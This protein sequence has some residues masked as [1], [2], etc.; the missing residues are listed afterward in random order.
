MTEQPYAQWF[1]ADHANQPQGP[2]DQDTLIALLR[3]GKINQSS[4]IWKADMDTWQPLDKTLPEALQPF[5]AENPTASAASTIEVKPEPQTIL[6][7]EPATTTEAFEEDSP[8]SAGN[9]STE[10]PVNFPQDEA[11]QT[12]THPATVNV[13]PTQ[14][15]GSTTEK[16]I[17]TSTSAPT[18]PVSPTASHT[19]RPHTADPAAPAKK[20]KGCL[21]A[22]IIGAVLFFIGLIIIAIL[23][24]I[25]IPAY[26]EYTIRSKVA[27]AIAETATYKS[28]VESFYLEHDR[29]PGNGEG[30]IPER[31][32][33]PG[34]NLTDVY[35][36]K[37]LNEDQ[38]ECIIAPT[39]T[40]FGDPELDDQELWMSF[41]ADKNEWLCGA[42]VADKYLPA[43][44]K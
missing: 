29:C 25:A 19:P 24:A 30:G 16:I 5:S 7:P 44:C 38:Y 6:Q 17:P 42:T 12:Q 26:Q 14:T 32:A 20:N 2:V 22:A 1:Y 15:S 37:D 34:N 18:S 13:S 27:G 31:D 21:I 4:L 23:A 33:F 41:D 3:Q 28:A 40:G 10:A 39:L 43:S 35:V 11:R 36:G 8:I 9:E